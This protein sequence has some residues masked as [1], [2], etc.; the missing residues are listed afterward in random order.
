MNS[1]N[2]DDI[3][4]IMQIVST[5]TG[6]IGL[7]LSNKIAIATKVD[8]NF[9]QYFALIIV[10]LG[11]IPIINNAIKNEGDFIKSIVYGIIGVVVLK[12]LGLL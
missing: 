3:R 6:V 12:I 8:N 2:K 4:L 10:L 1:N 9:I 7:F 11:G 5:L